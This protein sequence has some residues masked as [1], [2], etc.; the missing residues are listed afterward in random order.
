MDETKYIPTEEEIR[1]LRE[2]WLGGER[3]EGTFVHRNSTHS[4]SRRLKAG[5]S[6][7]DYAFGRM[8]G[9]DTSDEVEAIRRARS[10]ADTIVNTMTPERVKVTVGGKDSYAQGRSLSNRNNTINVATDFFDRNDLTIGQKTDILIGESVHEAAH[11]LHSDFQRLNDECKKWDDSEKRIRKYINNVLE[12]ERVEYLVGEDMSGMADYIA[13]L[14]QHMSANDDVRDMTENESEG[15]LDKFTRAFWTCI[16]YPSLI[17]DEEIAE[18]YDYLNRVRTVC[19]PFPKTTDEVFA[20]TDAIIGIMKDLIEEE[21]KQQ[22]PQNKDETQDGNSQNEP[23][24]GEEQPQDAPQPSQ[25]D[26]DDAF[27]Q[28][29]GSK[30]L[31][32]LLDKMEESMNSTGKCGGDSRTLQYDYDAVDYANGDADK[33]DV[34]GAGDGDVTYVR[35]VKGNQ[36]KYNEALSEVKSLVPSMRRILSCQAEDS[37]YT[38]HGMKRG[39]L[40]TNRFV[41]LRTGNRNIFSRHGEIT[42]EGACVCI[43][44]DES[45]SMDGPRELAARKAAVLVNEAVRGIDNLEVFVYGFTN[46]EFNVYCE[47]N[48]TDR[49]GIG[50]TK[51]SGGTPTGKAMRIAGDRVRRLTTTNCLM[52]V[53][54]DGMPNDSKEVQEQDVLLRKKGFYP[55]GIGI[56]SSSTG[57]ANIFKESLIITDLTEFAPRLGRFTKK[58]M[59]RIIVKEDNLE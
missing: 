34:L 15:P 12:D 45:G 53:M 57:V 8:S 1:E 23:G 58:Y 41:S 24:S 38:L 59:S 18:N 4:I 26:I 37:D 49:Y 43:L 14:K 32:D 40:N 5:E 21:I 42:T 6:L 33:A 27:K 51:S 36:S 30:S 20:T 25:K 46:N 11:I 29:L 16:R 39:K 35:N 28:A 2:D 54:T 47:R 13:V 52:L 10:I 3:Q 9:K 44:V 50:S 22:V 31:N 17:T 56:D 55:I 48:A 7:S 19:Q